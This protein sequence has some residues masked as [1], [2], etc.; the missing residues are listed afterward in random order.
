M[1]EKCIR[2]LIEGVLNEKISYLLY[3]NFYLNQI[4]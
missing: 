4:L 1:N 3:F 2:K